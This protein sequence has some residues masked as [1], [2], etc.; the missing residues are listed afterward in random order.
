MGSWLCE[1]LLDQGERVVALRRDFDPES[2]FEAEGIGA[3]CVVVLADLTDPASLLR[4]LA[5]NDVETVFHLAA[6]A[7]VAQANRTPLATWESNV[8][9]TY[10]LMEACRAYVNAGG[11]LK[12]VVVASSDKAYGQHDHL[13]L[14]E[15]FDLR[16]KNPY[17]VSKACEDMIA[18]SYAATFDLPLAVT[19]LANVYG[20]GDLAW[21]R[22]VPETAR[23]LAQGHRPQIRSDGTAERD[24]LY[25]D[26]AVDAYLTVA[27]SLDHLGRRGRVWNA[28]SD[29]PVRV[30]DV[31]RRL[32]SASGRN[33]DPEVLGTATPDGEIER[34]YVDSSAIRSELGWSANWDLDRGLRASW[35]WYR[36]RYG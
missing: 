23:A 3:R 8:R 2:R 32:I 35:E 14:R 11:G 36:D 9:G 30:L 12:R 28:G 26:D 6:Q 19:R 4:V 16:A 7:I 33:L 10:M 21:S 27:A 13:P 15:D 31:V 25:V 1:R 24:Y 18:R 22:L 29:R 5:E 17:D 20:P 34:Q